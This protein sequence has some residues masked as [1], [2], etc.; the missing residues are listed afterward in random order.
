MVS[1]QMEK[2]ANENISINNC[3]GFLS[4]EYF[5]SIPLLFEVKNGFGLEIQLD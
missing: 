1:L 4:V 2:L 5:L 3:F